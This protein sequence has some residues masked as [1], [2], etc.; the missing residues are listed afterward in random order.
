M[1][2]SAT[3]VAIMVARTGSWRMVRTAFLKFSSTV[4]AGCH[5][6]LTVNSTPNLSSVALE[7]C[8]FE[9]TRWSMSQNYKPPELRFRALLTE[10]ATRQVELVR[11]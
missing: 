11:A 7:L 1:I 3:S 8:A 6:R 5:P 9:P 4:N 2:A 10:G